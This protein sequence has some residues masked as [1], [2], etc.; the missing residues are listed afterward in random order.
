MGNRF[1]ENNKKNRKNKSSR[2]AEV[3]RV[4]STDEIAKEEKKR[5]KK[6][7]KD[8]KKKKHPRLWLTIKIM[9]IILLLVVVIGAGVF[10]GIVMGLFGDEFKLTEEELLIA[11]SNSVI[12]DEKGKIIATLNGDENREII[13]K[14]D[15]P[16]HLPLAFV[17]IEDERFFT[18]SGVD[19]KRTAAA[20][21]TFAIGRGESSFGGSTITQQLVKNITKDDDDSG[22]AGVFRKAKE[23]S[24]AYQVEKLISKDQI[25]ELY[26]NIIFLRSCLIAI[27]LSAYF[28]TILFDCNLSSFLSISVCFSSLDCDFSSFFAFLVVFFSSSVT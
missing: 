13:S 19:L 2:N 7:K 9:F 24:K 21:L 11:Y 28:S 20:T 5:N 3:T 10:V 15:M 17:A 4:I 1:K 23:I 6:V 16:K 27:N 25:L 14:D 18:H 26:S 8:K 22:M 12:V